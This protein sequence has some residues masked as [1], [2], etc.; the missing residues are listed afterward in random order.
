MNGVPAAAIR[1]QITRIGTEV[2][3]RVFV[4]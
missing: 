1:E 2:V 3:P 4:G